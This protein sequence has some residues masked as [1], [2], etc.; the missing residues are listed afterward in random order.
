[1]SWSW[2]CLRE[3]NHS[4][5]HACHYRTYNVLPTCLSCFIA[6]TSVNSVCV[7]WSAVEFALA[8]ENMNAFW[9]KQRVIVSRRLN[10]FVLF[11]IHR[12]FVIVAVID[13][14]GICS[15]VGMNDGIYVTGHYSNFVVGGL[16][17]WWSSVAC[18]SVSV[19]SQTAGFVLLWWNALISNCYYCCIHYCADSI[20]IE[21]K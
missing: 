10:H 3:W 7:A 12:S 2:S 8:T 16:I 6:Y 9:L 21:V 20:K 4:Y 18:V 13:C 11:I 19:W 5:L 14:G 17:G 15:C 1:M